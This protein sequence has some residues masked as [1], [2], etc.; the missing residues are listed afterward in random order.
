[1]LQVKFV[2]SAVPLIREAMAVAEERMLIVNTQW[3]EL[4]GDLYF[5][6]PD[7]E[8][9]LWL[10][11]LNE[12]AG[13]ESGYAA[14]MDGIEDMQ[15]GDPWRR[16]GSFASES[17]GENPVDLDKFK[18]KEMDALEFQSKVI[19]KRSDG[20]WDVLGTRY[21]IRPAREVGVFELVQDTVGGKRVVE[22]SKDVP[23]LVAQ[24]KRCV[25]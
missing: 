22:T 12:L 14:I 11:L 7:E 1:M 18:R 16:V 5:R 21:S 20:G 19:A 8:V 2:K 17:I 9:N 3:R 13:E 23:M 25:R 4:N 10:E 6:I 24:A 15:Q